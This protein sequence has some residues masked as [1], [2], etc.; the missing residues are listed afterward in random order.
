LRDAGAAKIYAVA[1]NAQT[2]TPAAGV[3]PVALDITKP[4]QVAA[5]ARSTRRSRST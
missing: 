4:E 1:R 5:A 3:E 2:I